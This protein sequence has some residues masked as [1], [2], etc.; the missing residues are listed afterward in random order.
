[1]LLLCA[2][3]SKLHL[4]YYQPEIS[5]NIWLNRIPHTLDSHGWENVDNILYPNP[6]NLSGKAQIP[7]AGGPERV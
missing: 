1:M 4:A 3:Q 7:F 5:I 6:W 2:A